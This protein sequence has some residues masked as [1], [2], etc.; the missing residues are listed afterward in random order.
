MITKVTKC[1]VVFVQCIQSMIES[2]H[3]IMINST[4]LRLS[5]KIVTFNVAFIAH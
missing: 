1:A 4:G 3:N 5:M 2:L